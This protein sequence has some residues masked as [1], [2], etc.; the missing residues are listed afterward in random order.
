MWSVSRRWTKFSAQARTRTV[1][2]ASQPHVCHQWCQ[3]LH[4][5]CYRA[6]S[7]EIEAIQCI[8]VQSRWTG[9]WFSQEEWHTHLSIDAILVAMETWFFL[10]F[11]TACQT[12]LRFYLL[13]QLQTTGYDGQQRFYIG[14]FGPIVNMQTFHYS[15]KKILIIDNCLR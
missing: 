11:S 14:L 6:V 13:F 15:P 5:I 9:T 2:R 3:F 12:K 4:T 8:L 10:W 1:V 7:K